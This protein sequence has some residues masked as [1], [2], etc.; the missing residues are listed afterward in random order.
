M[1]KHITFAKSKKKA[2]KN[3][4]VAKEYAALQEE[5]D[6]ID[7]LITARKRAKLSQEDVAKRLHTRQPAVA[8]LEAGAFKRATVMTLQSYAEA[9]GCELKIN[10]VKKTG[11]KSWHV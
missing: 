2:L 5:F 1:T 3:K 4:E 7:K 10:L 11:E 8:R 9:V 6:L